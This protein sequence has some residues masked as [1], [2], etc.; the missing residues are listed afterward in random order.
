MTAPPRRT[1][2]RFV[3]FLIRFRMPLLG[4]AVLLTFV[5]LP[6]ARQIEFDQRIE[7][8]YAADDPVLTD[9]LASKS[10]FGG[11]EFVIF[12]Y[13]DQQLY[14]GESTKVSDVS[15]E[16]MKQLARELKQVPGV[17]E[18]SFQQ[19]WLSTRL[20]YRRD[21]VRKLLTGVLVGEDLQ[22]TAIVF[23]LA[24]E[25]LGQDL[26]E[27]PATSLEQVQQNASAAV[28]IDDGSSDDPDGD[29]DSA[30]FEE[31]L[32]QPKEVVSRGETIRRI[33]EIAARQNFPIYIAGEP[34]QIHDMFRYVEEDGD[35][36]FRF[37]LMLLAT[38]LF[39]FF[40]SLRWVAIALLVVWSTIVWTEAGL[41]LAGVQL[42]MVSSMLNSL[43]TIVGVATVTHLTVRFQDRVQRAAAE[44]ALRQTLTELL[45]AVFWTCATTAVGFAALLSSSIT[46]VRSF[47]L[48]MSVAMLVVLISVCMIVP[49]SVLLG[50]F[51]P[52][53]PS[54][55]NSLLA[56]MLGG[57]SHLIERRPRSLVVI[58]LVLVTFSAFGLRRIRVETDFS[59]N[60]D[61]SSP[62]VTSLEFV[63]QRLGGAGT[64]EVNFPAPAELNDEYLLRVQR[65]ADRLRELE[66]VGPGKLRKVI[67]VTD[68]L[69]LVMFARGK[70]AA[71]K[72]EMLKSF[73]PEF[74]NSLY[75]PESGRM[76][77][78]L[79][80]E[81][82]QS[83]ETKNEL[84]AR[85]QQIAHEEF[86]QPEDQP[87]TTGIYVLLTFLIDSLMSDQLVSFGLAA[88]GV[89]TV[90]TIAFR[91]LSIGLISLV[92][93]L[94][95][96]I[97]V[98]GTMGWVGVPINI[99]TAMIASVSMGLT[100]DNSIHFL[101]SF[102]ESRADG[103]SVQDA[104]RAAHV[105][106]G[107]ALVFANLALIAGF[108]VLTLSHFIPLV[109]FGVLVSVAM[110]GGL[111]GNLIL[112]PLML[113]WRSR[114]D[115]P[116][117]ERQFRH[118]TGAD[119]TVSD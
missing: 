104:L 82:Q 59:K 57:V 30:G 80:A 3:G 5:A 33:R 83:A 91:S 48:M 106:V 23:R 29:V 26:A 101:H 9:F 78:L 31:E 111:L 56:P 50:R 103:M 46:P 63:E 64:W 25:Q 116:A 114:V 18:D 20:P 12:A 81:E 27:S 113:Q 34:I 11:D 6:I 75:S 21:D 37:S 105:T 52:H 102:H 79:R 67:C 51:A 28:S 66:G 74:A 94:F 117:D 44:D 58:T 65:L 95:P 49:G 54:T 99:A 2:E 88:A 61:A 47:G 112:L 45:P 73:Q 100:V 42:S 107:K 93:N 1:L 97:L 35:K 92:P 55:R 62:I 108:S 96:I 15:E 53:Q 41:V 72:F 24:P 84:I 115:S 7:S 110:F 77:I 4:L 14:E 90:M 43:V 69:D 109:Y 13:E 17:I 39:V 87:H 40:R 16:R 32:F 36:L 10:W 98:I 86:S 119:R 22:T 68:G 38:V 118:E 19:L 71:K 89:V 70:M 76:R 60:F 8:L 85:V